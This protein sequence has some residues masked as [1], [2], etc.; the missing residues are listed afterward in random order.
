MGSARGCCP[1]KRGRKLPGPTYQWRID[2]E[3][4]HDM[5]YWTRKLGCTEGELRDAVQIV[6]QN[7]KRIAE[8]LIIHHDERPK[9]D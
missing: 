1:L 5:R 9:K 3:D 4:E 6:G 8:Y 7:A 2:P